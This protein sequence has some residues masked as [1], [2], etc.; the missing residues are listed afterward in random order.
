MWRQRVQPFPHTC[1]HYIHTYIPVQWCPPFRWLRSN[2]GDCNNGICHV[3]KVTTA[4]SKNSYYCFV[5]SAILR[6]RTDSLR[7]CRMWL[8]LI[9]LNIHRNGVLMVVTWLVPHETAAVSA[10]VLCTPYNHA[11]VYSVISFE[12]TYARF[13]CVFSC[14]LPPALLAEWPGSFT[15]YCGNTQV[16]RILK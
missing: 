3:M 12:A 14:N 10:H 16:E 4:E 2:F 11:P 9:V 5:Y 13:A 7:S 8:W 15:C 6:S 1:T